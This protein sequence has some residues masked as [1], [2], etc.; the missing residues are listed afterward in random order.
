MLNA[1]FWMDF[2]TVLIHFIYFTKLLSFYYVF[3][4]LWILKRWILNETHHSKS[5]I[6]HSTSLWWFCRRCSP[7]PFPNRVVKPAMADGTGVKSGRVGS[8]HIYFLKKRLSFDSLFFFVL[9]AEL[10]CPTLLV[11]MYVLTTKF[12]K[13]LR[14]VCWKIR[15]RKRKFGF[16]RNYIRNRLT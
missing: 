9:C 16:G 8:C 12:T 6:H 13:V 11:V 4:E 3:I 5:N 1:E 2:K 15:P 7:L 10:S 14:K